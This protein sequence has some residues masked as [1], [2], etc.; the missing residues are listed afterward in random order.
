MVAVNPEILVWARESQALSVEEAARKLRFKDTTR[1]SAESK[2]LLLE[3][4]KKEPSRSKLNDMATTYRQPLLAFYLSEPPRKGNR[5]TD[6]RSLV[7]RSRNPRA[8]AFLDILMRNV[9]AAQ[10]LVRDILEDDEFKP[11]DFVGSMQTR[12]GE[13]AVAKGIIATLNFD[14]HHFRRSGSYSGAFAY[15]RDL[16][17][18]KGIFVLRLSDLGNHHSRIPVEVFRGFVY[19]DPFA[20]F[21]VINRNDAKVCLFLYSF[22]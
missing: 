12:M 4:G 17:E 16:I 2:L 18:S 20:P 13:D 14:L 11:L 21:M 7:Q 9:K 19:A 1:S 22:A 10:S 3:T 8:N 15:L 5:G 6:F